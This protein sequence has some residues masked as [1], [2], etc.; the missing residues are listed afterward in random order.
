MC[1]GLVDRM[2]R[3]CTTACL[4]PQI[5]KTYLTRAL[6]LGKLRCLKFIFNLLKQN[7]V[8]VTFKAGGFVSII[9]YFT[10]CHDPPGDLCCLFLPNPG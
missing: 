8:L 5:Q 4:S 7:Q 1:V 3:H 9:P 6:A 10:S 2:D